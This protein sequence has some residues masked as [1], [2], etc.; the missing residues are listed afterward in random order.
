MSYSYRGYGAIPTEEPQR[1]PFPPPAGYVPPPPPPGSF[2]FLSWYDR[3]WTSRLVVTHIVQHYL[4]ICVLS[5][6]VIRL[7]WTRTSVSSFTT[8]TT[9]TTWRRSC[10]RLSKW[11]CWGLYPTLFPLVLV[12]LYLD[13]YMLVR[14]LL[15]WLLLLWRPRMLLII[16]K[17]S[18]NK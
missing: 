8:T 7:L 11:S 6:H 15:L 9:T 2:S 18:W 4:P 14:L 12:V 13:V 5:F 3:L 10:C 16:P 1:P 17:C